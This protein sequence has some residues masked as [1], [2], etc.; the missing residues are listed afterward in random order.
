MEVNFMLT[1]HIQMITNKACFE[2]LYLLKLLSSGTGSFSFSWTSCNQ[3]SPP[4]ADIG[5]SFCNPF[6]IVS[7][8]KA[9]FSNPSSVSIVLYE[10]FIIH[11]THKCSPGLQNLQ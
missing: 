7:L 6:D 4:L 5:L 10:L 9:G 1:K 11:S 2:I 8:S 3:V